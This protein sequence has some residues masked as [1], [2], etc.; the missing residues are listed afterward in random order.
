VDAYVSELVIA[1]VEKYG[2]GALTVSDADIARVDMEISS[3]E[4]R[5]IR[6]QQELASL[7]DHPDLSPMT[8]VR[9]IES[10]HDKKAALEKEREELRS[11]R[12]LKFTVDDI[13]AGWEGADL[14]SERM[15]IE[16]LMIVTINPLP[17]HE[18]EYYGHPEYVEIEWRKDD[19]SS[20]S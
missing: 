15:M 19:S 3:L 18:S 8:I 14:A 12:H 9:S 10:F 17:S 7:A 4:R 2:M 6:A 5:R 11:R 20:P 1:W 13:R 16:A